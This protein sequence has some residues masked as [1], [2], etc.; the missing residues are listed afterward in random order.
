MAVGEGVESEAVMSQRSTSGFNFRRQMPPKKIALCTGLCGTVG[1][2]LPL[3][4]E[5]AGLSLGRCV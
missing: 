1:N 3:V 2:V 5:V 4:W